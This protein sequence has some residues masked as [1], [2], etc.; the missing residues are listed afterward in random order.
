ML[1]PRAMSIWAQMQETNS[2]GMLTKNKLEL[3]IDEQPQKFV[4]TKIQRS[5]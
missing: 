5:D 4:F 2:K 3:K 1:I